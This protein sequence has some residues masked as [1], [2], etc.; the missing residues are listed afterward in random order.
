MKISIIG[1]SLSS[2]WG[3][4]H[5]TTYRSLVTALRRRG[6]AVDFFERAEPWYGAHRDLPPC[7]TLHFY[8]SA[9]ELLHDWG[10]HLSGSD[11]IVIGSF[12]K[13][14]PMLTRAL[15]RSAQGLLAF[16]DIDTPVTV[17]QLRHERC[18]YMEK[19]LVPLFD[20]YLSFSGGA[21]LDE[22]KALGARW[23]VPFYCS[24]DPEVHAPVD[25]PRDVDL[26]YLG[27]YSADRHAPLTE[28][29]LE[30]AATWAAGRFA[31]A[32]P[33]YPDTML[34][35]ANV[36]HMD[37]VPPG[38]HPEFYC[39]QR[40][41]LNLTRSHARLNGSSPS[42]RLFEAACCGTPIIS[43]YWDGLDAFFQIGEEVLVADEGRDV[44]RHVRE[45]PEDER[46]AIGEAARARVLAEHTGDRRAAELESHLAAV[47]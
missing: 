16:Y 45:M 9:E 26:G 41:T 42:V 37:H 13:E 5:A 14:T 2:S 12:V 38:A 31:V 30:P 17:A 43:D 40:F 18:E 21:V 11:L 44:L 46:V 8:R 32:G 25:V 23:P 19:D 4:G 28:L 27:K 35:P 10:G 36:R 33:Q 39:S 22:L 47:S 6:H 3:N 7:E 29:L 20:L 24:V 15:R 1:L 34:W